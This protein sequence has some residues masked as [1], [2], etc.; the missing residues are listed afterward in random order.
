VENIVLE[1]IRGEHFFYTQN[2]N[3]R[4]Q[5]QWNDLVMGFIML[6]FFC[7]EIYFDGKKL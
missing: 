1:N 4:K 5:N 2:I 3:Q 6:E 7:S